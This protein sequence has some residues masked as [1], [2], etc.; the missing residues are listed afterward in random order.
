MRAGGGQQGPR[1]LVNVG[2][3]ATASRVRGKDDLLSNVM[4]VG[5]ARLAAFFSSSFFNHL[6]PGFSLMPMSAD[7]VLM[8]F[9]LR[10]PLEEGRLV[11]MRLFYRGADV[12]E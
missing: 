4:V 11:F 2:I 12:I 8:L 5:A 10:Y 3:A 1:L 7:V 9:F 6:S